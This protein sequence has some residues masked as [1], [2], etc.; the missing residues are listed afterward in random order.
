MTVYNY[1]CDVLHIEACV[2][3]PNFKDWECKG[4]FS[5]GDAGC[6]AYHNVTAEDVKKGTHPMMRLRAEMN[7]QINRNIRRV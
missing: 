3:C 4:D 5:Q 7:C 6:L 1:M 2:D